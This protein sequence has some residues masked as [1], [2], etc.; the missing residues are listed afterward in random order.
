MDDQEATAVARAILNS[1]CIR[2]NQDVAL[3]LWVH[4]VI[5]RLGTAHRLLADARSVLDEAIDGESRASRMYMG[6]VCPHR[7]ADV[8]EEIDEFIGAPTTRTKEG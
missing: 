2:P 3:A 6:G 7:A 8:L 5:E 4:G 1:E